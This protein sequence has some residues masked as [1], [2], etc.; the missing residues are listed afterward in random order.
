MK[1]RDALA[2]ELLIEPSRIDADV[3]A[4]LWT[5]LA[6]PAVGIATYDIKQPTKRPFTPDSDTVLELFRF[7]LL[8]ALT[9]DGVRGTLDWSKLV[10]LQLW[11][12]RR[13][14]DEP[15]RQ[16]AIGLFRELPVVYGYACTT[17]EF[18]AHHYHERPTSRGAAIYGH[19]GTALKFP[20]YLPA[21]YW[22]NLFGPELTAGLAL[23]NVDAIAGVHR[24]T[25]DDNKSVLSLDGP[26]FVEDAALDARLA[27]SRRVAAALGD[28]YFY[29]R[30][31][32][33]RA[34]KMVPTLEPLRQRLSQTK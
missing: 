2:L 8:L 25:V 33:D 4:R 28:D 7:R 32:P 6:D 24:E 26:P 30:D 5:R 3:F 22:L 12:D 18:D 27:L 1:T 13:R 15:L 16:W 34:L 23:A 21:V 17:D 14:V 19:Q 20:E 31:R 10:G 29:D 9:G 11:V